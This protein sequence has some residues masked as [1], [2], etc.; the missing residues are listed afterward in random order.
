MTSVIVVSIATVLAIVGL[1]MTMTGFRKPARVPNAASQAVR[2]HPV[3]LSAGAL[4]E[5]TYQTAQ[6][7]DA[8]ISM[9]EQQGASV[10]RVH[11]MNVAP[12]NAAR[13]PRTTVR[14][15]DKRVEY[16]NDLLNRQPVAA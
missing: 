9:L 2:R 16:F 6:H 7:I 5:K 10:R 1:V 14:P 3:V 11:A 12:V 15:S 4:T 8:V 13:H